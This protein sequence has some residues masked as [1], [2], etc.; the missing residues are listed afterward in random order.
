MKFYSRE[1]E[2]ELLGKIEKLSKRTAQITFVVGRR[3]IGKT[4]LL[5]KATENKE[6]L[7]FFIA[8]KVRHCCVQ[9]L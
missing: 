5:L 7:Y 4:S 9:N 1:N 6:V 2:L 3:R 8:K